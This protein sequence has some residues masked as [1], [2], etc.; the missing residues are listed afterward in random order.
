M[1]IRDDIVAEAREW[2]GTP[3]H[4]QARTKHAGVDCIG[5]IVALAQKFGFAHTDIAAYPHQ[6]IHGIF[7]N[8]INAQTHTIPLADVQ[9]GDMLLFRF[10][11]EPQHIALVTNINPLTMTHAYAQA[12]CC[13]E[14]AVDSTWQA[15]LCGVRRFKELA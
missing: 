1:T 2:L 13:V 11:A 15:R 3:F 12:R 8:A 4:H 10:E 6:P 7:I 14:H 9:I 5:L